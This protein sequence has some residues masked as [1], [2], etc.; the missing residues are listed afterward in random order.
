MYDSYRC[1][2]HSIMNMQQECNLWYINQYFIFLILFEEN[3]DD[4]FSMTI[5]STLSSADPFSTNHTL[6]AAFFVF[7]FHLFFVLSALHCA[8]YFFPTKHLLILLGTLSNKTTIFDWIAVRYFAR[9]FILR[10]FDLLHHSFHLEIFSSIHLVA[11]KWF[12]RTFDIISFVLSTR[13][14]PHQNRS[15]E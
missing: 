14:Y 12:I 6:W 8:L 11:R 3:H 5:I 7:F 9:L 1:H 10:C 2:R 4:F 13:K 15:M